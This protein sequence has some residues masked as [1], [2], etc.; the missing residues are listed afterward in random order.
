MKE[1]LPPDPDCQV[2]ISRIGH[3]SRLSMPRRI[4][5]P[6]APV[7]M[8]RL[9]AP[10]FFWTT[11]VVRSGEI[12]LSRAP[13]LR[14]ADLQGPYT[15]QGES[16]EQRPCRG[17]LSPDRLQFGSA[18]LTVAADDRYPVPQTRGRYNS[19]GKVWHLVPRNETHHLHN[20]GIHTSV[21]ILSGSRK[22][23]RAFSSV[24]DGIRPFSAR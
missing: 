24:V 4:P 6:W 15:S 5:C 1:T 18:N 7:R 19:I 22:I 12:C 3:N 11:T 2:C 14:R 23:S 13:S 21:R 9:L 16:L 17:V 20:G 10:V 8:P